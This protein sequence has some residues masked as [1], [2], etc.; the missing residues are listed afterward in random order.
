MSLRQLH[1]RGSQGLIWQGSSKPT[2][3]IPMESFCHRLNINRFRIRC[4]TTKRPRHQS[5]QHRPQ[6]CQGEQ[7]CGSRS[8]RRARGGSARRRSP[9]GRLASPY[10]RYRSAR[11]AQQPGCWGSGATLITTPV[12]DVTIRVGGI[13]PPRAAAICSTP[14]NREHAL[15]LVE[16]DVLKCR[17]TAGHE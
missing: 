16:R 1:K 9:R 10:W 5:R 6:L 2:R 14:R 3:T 11:R 12:C 4:C 7:C 17:I 13:S 15:A 8:S